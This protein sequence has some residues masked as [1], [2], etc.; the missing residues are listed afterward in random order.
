[1]TV[2]FGSISEQFSTAT[3]VTLAAPPP[4]PSPPPPSPPPVVPV[5]FVSLEEKSNGAA[6]LI[7]TNLLLRGIQIE[8]T[9]PVSITPQ[10]EDT[11]VDA[12]WT[13]EFE[14]AGSFVALGEGESLGSTVGPF[15]DPTPIFC[16]FAEVEVDPMST[17]EF[18]LLPESIFSDEFGEEAPHDAIPSQQDTPL[19]ALLCPPFLLLDPNFDGML[20]VLDAVLISN[21]ITGKTFLAPCQ[22][23]AADGNQDGAVNVLDV[24][25]VVGVVTGAIPNPNE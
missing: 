9:V 17:A 6:I 22:E 10:L 5:V 25:A 14:N 3:C 18:C 8:F 19:C 2:S 15:A 24:V 23:L 1:M 13:L 11:L 4:P 7:Q 20:N 21:S 16:I 12:G